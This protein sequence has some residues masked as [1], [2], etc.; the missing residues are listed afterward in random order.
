MMNKM[1]SISIHPLTKP[2]LDVF[3]NDLENYVESDNGARPILVKLQADVVRGAAKT[4]ADAELVW[5]GYK[6]AA[7]FAENNRELF[8]RA[9]QARHLKKGLPTKS[10][11]RKNLY[12]EVENLYLELE[13]NLG[14]LLARQTIERELTE[15]YGE[16]KGKDGSLKPF[17][18]LERITQIFSNQQFFQFPPVGLDQVH[19]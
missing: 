19:Y 13:P 18:S 8:Y 14:D 6:L 5:H 12:D 11:N 2:E 7:F 17:R 10:E 4:D 3:L 16:K 15:K 9:V 1:V